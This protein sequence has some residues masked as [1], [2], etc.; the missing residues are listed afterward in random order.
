VDHE[1]GDLH[2]PSPSTTL[3]AVDRDGVGRG[4]LR[5]V[6][7]ERVQKEQVVAARNGVAEMVVDALV[8]A[9]ERGSP[10][11]RGE[12]D[13]GLPKHLH[14]VFFGQRHGRNPTTGAEKG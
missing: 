9:I 7:A 3:P 14:V 10:E 1:R 6:R 5:P 12:V 8:V 13:L 2:S 11:R 4:Q